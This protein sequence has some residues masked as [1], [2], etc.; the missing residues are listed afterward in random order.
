VFLFLSMVAALA[1]SEPRFVDLSLRTLRDLGASAR[2]R[3]D[4]LEREGL[5]ITLADDSPEAQRR[6]RP[7]GPR[8]PMA[9]RARRP[10]G[11]TKSKRAVARRS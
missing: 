5:A 6:R 3:A 10:S 1:E 9:P 11:N 8:G 2:M 4:V 7:S